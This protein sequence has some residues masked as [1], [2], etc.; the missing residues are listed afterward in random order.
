MKWLSGTLQINAQKCPMC[1][2]DITVEILERALADEAKLKEVG[3][4]LV[5][6]M[7]SLK[8]SGAVVR[9]RTFVQDLEAEP[10]LNSEVENGAGLDERL[11]AQELQDLATDRVGSRVEEEKVQEEED[12]LQD[13]PQHRF[14]MP[15]MF[16]NQ[17]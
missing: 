9:T 2:S 12:Q 13:M 15:I 3:Y 4:D 16:L 11:E 7:H 6:M 10:P 17:S 5:T 8:S 1:N 14:R